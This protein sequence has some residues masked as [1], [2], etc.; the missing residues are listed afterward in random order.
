MELGIHDVETMGQG[1]AGGALAAEGIARAL[2]DTLQR[3]LP[4][5]ARSVAAWRHP[6]LGEGLA[7]PHGDDRALCEAAMRRVAEPQPV[8]TP[9]ASIASTPPGSDESTAQTETSNPPNAW[10]D[11]IDGSD[12]IRIA[13]GVAFTGEPPSWWQHGAW[14]SLVGGVVLASLRKAEADAR[15]ESLEKS[16]HLQRALYQ[17]SDLAGSSLEIHEMMAQ[18]HPIVGSLM[19]A[20]NFYLVLYDAAAETIRY[21]YFADSRDTFDPDAGT[22]Y[23]AHRDEHSMTAALLR[24]GRPLIGAPR[25]ILP[26]LGIPP[27]NYAGGPLSEDWLGVPL[28]RGED[29]CGAIVVQNYEHAHC[30]DDEDRALLEYVGQH[31]LTAVDRKTAQTQLE[32]RVGERTRDLQRINLTLLNEVQER[33]RAEKLQQALYRITELSVASKSLDRFFADL[34]SIIGELLYARNFYVALLTQDGRYLEFQY[35]VDEIDTRS[36]RERSRARAKGITEYVIDTARPLLA[37]RDVIHDLETRGLV[38]SFGPLAHC[39]LGVPL[40]RDGIAEGIIGVQSYTPTIRFV[41]RDQELLTFVAHHVDVALARKRAQ[42]HLLAAHAELETRVDSRTREL[43]DANRELREQINERLRAEQRLRHQA[44]HDDL[45]N[46]PNR[47]HLQERLDDAIARNGDDEDGRPFAVM[48]LDIDRFKLINDSIGHAAGDELLIEASRR[49]L[50]A[51][52]RDDSVARLG[53]DEFAILADG[54]DNPDDAKHYAASILRS[55]AQPLWVQGR[56]LYPS[57]SIGIALWHPRYRKS[58]ELLRDAD[59]AMYRAKRLGRNRS[60]VFDEEMRAEAT[61]LLDL[62]ADLRRAILHDHFEPYFQTIRRLSDG[63]TVGCE[64]LVRWRHER[65]GLLGPSQFIGV[66][67]DGSLIEQVDWLMYRHVIASMSDLPAGYVSIN[68]SPRHFLSDN[69]VDRILRMLDEAKQDPQRLRIEITEVALVEDATRALQIL[70]VLRG[71]G[72][73]AFLDDFGTGFSALS[74]LHKFPIQGLKIDRSFVSGLD[75]EAS[76]ESLA[77]VRA[78]LAMA[79]TLGI[80]TIAEGIETQVQESILLDLGCQYGQGYLFGTPQA[81]TQA[82][83]SR[84]RR[85]PQSAA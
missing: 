41:E 34:H 45:T 36:A 51:V 3:T 78:I 17:I 74:Y 58:E 77:L 81:L 44:R 50:Q 38:S 18:V 9:S 66:G 47:A 37:D 1:G 56:E 25:E 14:V 12:G 19:S 11:R 49:I 84:I 39:W 23:P 31:I 35:A 57:A 85:T 13:L 29:V 63:Q 6:L 67:E 79:L 82:S 52:A 8:S 70:R 76:I 69:F 27:D 59:A 73:A 65:N 15:I 22:V 7:G 43:A 30:Y 48:F 83:G 40:T 61:R 46:L 10:I 20:E 75:G 2:F 5:G 80:E 32:A 16:K 72:I 28:R 24:H 68:V 55:L 60:I 42:D 53:G 26:T 54:L 71:Y 21:L 33:Q 64:A 62:E 4:E